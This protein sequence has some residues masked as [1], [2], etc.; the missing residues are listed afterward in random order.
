MADPL[1][2]LRQFNI[3]KKE[4][5]E[6]NDYIIFGD[7][8][9][10]KNVA[11][12][13]QI[14]SSADD[15]NRK[16]Y[17]TLECLLY[18]LK[19]KQVTHTH[20]VRQAGSE[21][22]PVVHRPD[23]KN[24]LAYLDGQINTT[25]AI[26]R[27]APIPS[28]RLPVSEIY[29]KGNQNSSQSSLNDQQNSQSSATSGS[30]GQN[31]LQRGISDDFATPNAGGKKRPHDPEMEKKYREEFAAK[32]YE[33]S[34]KKL[35]TVM[36]GDVTDKAGESAEG[37]AA[38]SKFGPERLAALRAKHL[39]VKRTTIIDADELS[40]PGSKPAELGDKEGLLISMDAEKFKIIKSKEKV[41]RTRSSILQSH[42]KDFFKSLMPM[43][44]LLTNPKDPS[45]KLIG[46]MQSMGTDMPMNPMYQQQPHV[47]AS[48][49][50]QPAAPK[51]TYN[52]Y[53][54]ER[55]V[56]LDIGV[57]I[58]T[59]KSFV[60]GVANGLTG[61]NSQPQAPGT[62][63]AGQKQNPNPAAQQKPVPPHP[64][65]G[66]PNPVGASINGQ[67]GPP[68][69]H[70]HHHHQHHHNNH[71]QVD[72]RHRHSSSSGSHTTPNSRPSKRQSTVPIIIIPATTTSLIN[73]YNAS[74]ILQDLTFAEGKPG[75]KARESEMLIQRKKLDGSHAFYKIIDNPVKLDA[76]DWNRVVAV[77]VQGPAWQFKGW[78]WG[79][80]PV[81]IF[82]RIKAFH[83][84]WDEQKLDDN[85]GKWNVNI[86]ELSR[87]KRHLDKANLMKFWSSLDA[88]MSKYK[89]FLKF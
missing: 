46:H 55:F 86:L 3:N 67:R 37:S 21:E 54:Q 81:E 85:V 74:T 31:D 66:P 14:Y 41:W 50:S 70:H 57:E 16:E 63:P 53:D 77:F 80:S 28:V 7:H 56:K 73:M 38:I 65:L 30:H 10:P 49:S 40:A 13:Y 87:N 47:T 88:F 62:N 61:I 83:L 43:L 84:K 18:F 29:K 23:R 35:A 58:D 76:D 45:K 82:S 33:P 71:D 60:S 69:H 11:T 17:Y 36:P 64:R 5:K 26:D 27:T 20:Y 24:L 25:P 22:I 15:S 68:S 59:K 2:Q 72:S 39:A 6:H 34:T 79:G 78:P 48:S 4:I 89:T 51:H 44:D 1:S 32:L 52:R 42:S 12:N 19:N 8:G 75:T 9:W